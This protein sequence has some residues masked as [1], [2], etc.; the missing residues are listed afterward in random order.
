MQAAKNNKKEKN[1]YGSASHVALL[2]LVL[3]DLV[4]VDVTNRN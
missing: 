4:L 2:S 3:V 1:H